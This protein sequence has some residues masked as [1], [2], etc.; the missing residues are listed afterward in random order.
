LRGRAPGV[1]SQPMVRSALWACAFSLAFG[2]PSSGGE[3]PD[4]VLVLEPASPTLPGDVPE[5]APPRFVL[6][7]DGQV[8]VGGTNHVASGRL[9]RG[10]ASDIEKQVEKVRRLPGLGSSVVFGPGPR[11]QRLLV[12]D[13]RHLDLSL[14]GDPAEAPPAL[15]PLASLVASLDSFDHPSLRPFSPV[16]YTLRARE[17]ALPGGCRAWAFTVPV[18]ECLQAPRIVPAAA[19]GGWPT[20]ASPASA[21]VGDK[22]YVVTLHPLLPGEKP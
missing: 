10:E 15:R 6:M 8:F 20:G 2:L 7:K 13:R 18:D 9:E 11:R 14:A 21:C 1:H 12:R 19:A 22:R 3:I 16:S 17:G 4:A 5:A